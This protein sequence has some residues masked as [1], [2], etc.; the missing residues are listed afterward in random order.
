MRHYE[1]F[2][3][4]DK[5]VEHRL[6]RAFDA[7]MRRGLGYL[8]KADIERFELRRIKKIMKRFGFSV[9]LS[10][11][12]I[13]FEDCGTGRRESFRIDEPDPAELA[14][15]KAGNELMNEG[16]LL[17]VGADGIPRVYHPSNV[18]QQTANRK[19]MQV[20]KKHGFDFNPNTGNC[21]YEGA[22]LPEL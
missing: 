12:D 6:V 2:Y 11:A 19:V 17:K 7:L 22:R 20:L 4:N 13:T 10:N 9:D 1:V 8:T 16:Y 5:E 18:D 15:G 14:L 21:S 3:F